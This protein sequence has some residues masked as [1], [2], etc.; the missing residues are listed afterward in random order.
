MHVAQL[1]ARFTTAAQNGDTSVLPPGTDW[2][3]AISAALAEG[4]AFLQQTYGEDMDSWAWGK[5]HTTSPQHT[6]S[7]AFPEAA[8]LLAPPKVPMSGDGDT[9]HSASYASS[10]PFD[11]TGTSVARYVFDLE[12]WSRSR[13]ITPLG[14]SGHPG[15]PHYT[16][17]VSVWR[18]RELIPMLYDWDQI[19][20]EAESKQELETGG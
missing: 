9:P 16:D 6:L 18:A 12:D 4:V 20:A 1:H 19:E 15:S 2:D 7:V 3:G 11:V 14:S 13:W 5:V 8:P 17:Q 10:E